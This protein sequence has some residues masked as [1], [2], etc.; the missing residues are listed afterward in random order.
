MTKKKR[1][2]AESVRSRRLTVG[3]RPAS[4]VSHSTMS[5]SKL[6]MS[7]VSRRELARRRPGGSWGRLQLI[8]LLVLLVV[9]VGVAAYLVGRGTL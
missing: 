2:S 8:A 7:S 3:A 1:L 5:Q 4:I 9:V 6:F